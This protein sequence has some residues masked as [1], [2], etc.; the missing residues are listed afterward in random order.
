MRNLILLGSALLISCG[1]FASH[2]VR[3]YYRSTGTYVAPH[4]SMDPGEARSTGLSYHNNVLVRN[5]Y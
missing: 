4:M 5:N 3:G 2:M 1:A